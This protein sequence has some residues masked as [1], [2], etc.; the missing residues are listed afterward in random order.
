ML[1][2][3]FFIFCLLHHSFLTDQLHFWSCSCNMH[4]CRYTQTFSL[5]YTVWI[6]GTKE[7]TFLGPTLL[8]RRTTHIHFP[9]DSPETKASFCCCGSK[10]DAHVIH[11]LSHWGSVI[12]DQWEKWKQC[13][14]EL[15]LYL[16]GLPAIHD[17]V[18]STTVISLFWWSYQQ[19]VVVMVAFVVE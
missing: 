4:I 5:L 19:E 6:T 3:P 18:N 16:D 10:Q 15:R 7:N 9:G 17:E 2:F 14:A 1:H 13:L 8:Q 12:N 11:N